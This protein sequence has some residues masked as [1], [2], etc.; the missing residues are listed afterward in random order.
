MGFAI[1]AFLMT[2]V[3]PW[4]LLQQVI[5]SRNTAYAEAVFRDRLPYSR[6]LSSKAAEPGAGQTGCA[7]AIVSLY[8]DADLA[9]RRTP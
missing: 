1:L 8:A 3:N 9:P 7:V 2:G 6:V 4:Y 5:L